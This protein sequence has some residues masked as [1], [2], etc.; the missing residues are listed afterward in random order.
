MATELTTLTLR[1]A[2]IS[3]AFIASASEQPQQTYPNRPI[4]LIVPFGAGAGTDIEARIVSSKR[5][6]AFNQ[7]VVVDNRAGASGIIGAELGAKASPDGYTLTTAT[8]SHTVNP[9]LHKKLPYDIVKDFAP[10][11]LLMEY[12]FL[13][14]VR[15][16]LPVKSVA[17]LVA[18]AKAKP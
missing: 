4:R 9:S 2:M 15:P 17:D 11:S 5:A 13:L 10:V 3:L 6:E 16:S 18:L 12:P 8:I 1:A 14:D 7:Q